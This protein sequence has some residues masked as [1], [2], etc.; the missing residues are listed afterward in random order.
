MLQ[1][2]LPQSARKTKMHYQIFRNKNSTQELFDLV[3]V[4]YKQV[5][6]E[7]KGL[8]CGVHKNMERGLFVN[9]QMHPRVESA[10]IHMQARAREAVKE[11]AAEEKVA[12]H[13]LWPAAQAPNSDLLSK[14]DEE[15]CAGLA[16][17]PASRS[18]MAW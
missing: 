3:N 2:F 13:Q 14:E 15:F 4:L 17:A 10:A 16:C 1:R 18:G 11:H 6:N 5:M 12:G 7:D 9:G 8:A